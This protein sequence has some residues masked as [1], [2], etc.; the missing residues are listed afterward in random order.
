MVAFSQLIRWSKLVASRPLLAATLLLGCSSE[1]TTGPKEHDWP[2][3]LSPDTT[4]ADAPQF[5]TKLGCQTDFQLL[6]GAPLDASLPGAR[7]QK[8]VLDLL[9]GDQL[10]FQN[11]AKY[12]IH[13]DFVKDSKGVRDEL[14]FSGTADQF[15]PQYF[16]PLNQR[17]F[18]LG[19]VTYYE[20]PKVWALEIAPYDTATPAM[21]ERLYKAVQDQAYFGPVLAFHPTSEAVEA[22]AKQ[23]ASNVVVKTTAQLYEGITYQPLN[24]GEAIGTVKIMKATDLATEYVSAR[25]I[26]V[27]DAVPND[28]SAVAAIVTN[29]FQTP[30]SHIN[31]LARSRGTPNMGLAG[32]TKH[33]DFVALNGKLA[34]ITVGAFGWTLSPAT[35]AESDAWWATHQPDPVVL[36]P[37]NKDVRDLR[38]I[39]LVTKHTD[40][41]PYVVLADLKESILAFGAKSA[42]YAVFDSDPLVPHKPAFAIPVYYYYEFMEQNGIFARAAAFRDDPAFAA[43]DKVRKAKLAALRETVLTGTFSQE[44]TSA[45]KAKLDK[46]YPGQSMRFR[47][48]TNAEDLD[49]FPC[50]GCY[51][52]HTGNP[53]EFGGDQMAA[54]LDAIR[55]T[56]ATAWSERT[57]YERELHKIEHNA[58]AM[59]LLVHT[60]FPAEEANGVAITNNIFDAT[61]NA[62]G[63]YINVQY[64]GDF[65]V[66]HPPTGITSDSFLY[67]L[68]SQT[69]IYYSHS[70]ALPAGH[71]PNV[72]SERQIHDLG[73][74]LDRLHVRFRHAY[75]KNPTDWY[76]IDSEFKFDNFADPTKPATLY[77]K[78]ARPYPV[79]ASISSGD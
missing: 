73:I 2:C 20:E 23:L 29:D 62:P 56:W 27:L 67:M 54:C 16:S 76:A 47:S 24:Q 59:G 52:S 75:Q 78:Q 72:L 46:D 32:A 63:F 50:A 22:T 8:V 40:E 57:Y 19:A 12:K 10:Y 70:N 69:T 53:G 33:A 17:A 31:V 38:D 9:H 15:L 79:N 5:L 1:T 7:S 48:S 6:S 64:G 13:F 74:A 71:G 39:G 21:I 66:V 26:V 36:P 37:I 14:L 30:L 77:I 55:K 25:D 3:T 43:D 51:D 65:E 44:F 34:K 49:G 58:V 18:L 28:I 41:P 42:H 11:T 35:Q 61:G 4:Q 68:Q 45:L 60:N